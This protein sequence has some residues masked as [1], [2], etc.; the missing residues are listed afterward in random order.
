M[1]KIIDGN[2][3]DSNANFIVHQVNCQAVMGSGVAKQVADNFPHVEKEYLKYC[4]HCK[5]NKKKL[6][7]SV[8]YVPVDSWALIM[9]DTMN[10]DRVDAYDTNYQYI[11]NLFGQDN[12]GMGEQHTDL[13]AMK[14]CFVDIREKAEK[15]GASIA[16]PY[17]IGSFRGGADW[18][19]VYKIIQDVFGKSKVDVEIWKYDKE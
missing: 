11:V 17:K 15:I 13:T 4:K 18:N 1:I 9:C 16:M 5:K 6:L 14:N 10:N 19:D 12:F 8:Q 3:F 2:L 7:G